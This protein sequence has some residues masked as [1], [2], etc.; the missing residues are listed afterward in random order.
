VVLIV[1]ASAWGQRRIADGA[2]ARAGSPVRVGIVQGNVPQDEKWTSTAAWTTSHYLELGR[3]LAGEGRL[4][5]MVFPETALPFYL[6]DPSRTEYRDSIAELA[7]QTQTPLLVG[8]LERQADR[9]YNR[10]F[11]FDA[12]GA[13]VGYA[14]KVHLVPFGEYLP[15]PWLFRYLEGLTAESGAFAAGAG[16][17]VLRLPDHGPAFGVFIC[18]ESIFPEIARS[19]TRNGAVFL[20]NITNDAWFGHS[21]APYQHFSMAVVRAVENGRPLLRVANTGISGTVSASGLIASATG[22]GETVARRASLAPRSATT[23]YT[24]HG[25]AFLL[26][27]ALFLAGSLAARLARRS[28]RGLD[29]SSTSGRA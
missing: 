12:A 1:L 8:S 7:R 11:L 14:D 19:L 13:V 20:L 24:D 2:L 21:A 22:L 18:Y 23:F 4:D 25:D 29:R 17:A 9:V 28:G 6:R 27:C 26:A 5:L 16:H 3:E 15:L 10:A